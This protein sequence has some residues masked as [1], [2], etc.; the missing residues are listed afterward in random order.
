MTTTTLFKRFGSINLAAAAIMALTGCSVRGPVPSN[1]ELSADLERNYA[2]YASMVAQCQAHPALKEVDSTDQESSWHKPGQYAGLK[3]DER[4]IYNS[5]Q[6]RLDDIG[7]ERMFCVRDVD[8]PKLPLLFVAFEV[9][10]DQPFSADRYL[11]KGLQYSFEDATT[12]NQSVKAH[13]RAPTERKN[14]FIYGDKLDQ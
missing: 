12:Q 13:W 11:H 10:F 4:D 7:I 9:Y 8:D 1:A 2:D 14:W 5:I 3:S 6:T